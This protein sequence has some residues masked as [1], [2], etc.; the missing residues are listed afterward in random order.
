MSNSLTINVPNVV[1]QNTPL[2]NVPSGSTAEPDY[3]VKYVPQSLTEEQKAQAR[4]NIGAA[5]AGEGGAAPEIDRYWILYTKG[6]TTLS[7]NTSSI[8]E[9]WMNGD[10]INGNNGVWTILANSIVRIKGGVNPAFVFSNTTDDI[11]LWCPNGISP[12]QP[13]YG[14]N[15]NVN[16]VLPQGGGQNIN[17]GGKVWLMQNKL[18]ADMLSMTTQTSVANSPIVYLNDT[19]IDASA[20][21]SNFD[22]KQSPC[23]FYVPQNRYA[24]FIQKLGEKGFNRTILARRTVTYTSIIQNGYELDVELLSEPTSAVKYVKIHS[25]SQFTLSNMNNRWAGL[26]VA[27]YNNGIQKRLYYNVYNDGEDTVAQYFEYT[28][29]CD[30]GENILIFAESSEDTFYNRL[31]IPTFIQS[32]ATNMWIEAQNIYTNPLIK[33]VSPSD[34]NVVYGLGVNNASFGYECGGTSWIYTENNAIADARFWWRFGNHIVFTDQ[35][36]SGIMGSPDTDIS[37]DVN[38]TM[39][40]PKTRYQEFVNRLQVI[41]AATFS[42]GHGN[43]LTTNIVTYDY[44]S[45]VGYKK[46]MN[47]LVAQEQADWNTIDNTAPS[48][49]KNKPAESLE[50]TMTDEDG[51]VITGT[52]VLTS[53]TITPAS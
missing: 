12:I 11:W 37:A 51:N 15:Y 3:N 1:K 24:E 34:V 41:F 26:P 40:V 5:A 14:N 21:P 16:L 9:V 2:R 32:G 47:N 29:T 53:K 23:W 18:F 25:D 20:L 49:I 44:I 19:T 13:V 38:C 33:Q 35:S 46:V 31:G 42:A 6:D 43:A 52:F 48:Y 8:L 50:L 45:E 22:W 39:Y 17:F 4:A 7:S 28:L 10:K 36:M 27:V 30:A